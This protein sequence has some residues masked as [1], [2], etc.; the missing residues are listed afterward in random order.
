[1]GGCPTVA[2]DTNTPTPSEWPK[3]LEALRTPPPED[4]TPP[5]PIQGA[6]CSGGVGARPPP[7]VQIWQ[8]PHQGQLSSGSSAAATPVCLTGWERVHKGAQTLDPER[9]LRT[10][11]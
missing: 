8:D 4:P 10:M 1:M 5:H 9:I 11:T 7:W 6:K 3:C 2:P